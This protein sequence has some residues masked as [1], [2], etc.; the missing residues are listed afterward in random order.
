MRIM[1]NK[2]MMTVINIA[3]V[4]LLFTLLAPVY[5][6]YHYINQLFYLAYFYLGIGM[7]AW[8]TRG[9][10][11]DGITYGFRRFTNRMSRNGDYMED[12]KDKPLPSKT[13]N[14]SWPRFFLFH[15]CVLMLGL[16]ILLLFYYLL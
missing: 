11:F 15:G 16:L 13:I 5:D 7:I 12:W 4:T 1:R 6:L 3:V 9:G 8:V 14:Q 10:F 2:W